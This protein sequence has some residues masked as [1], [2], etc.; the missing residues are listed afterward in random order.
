MSPEGAQHL[1]SVVLSAS[2]EAS[3]AGNPM[4]FHSSERSVRWRL[5]SNCTRCSMADS[6]SELPL[7]FSDQDLASLACFASSCCTTL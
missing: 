7:R 6:V 4:A 5:P 1:S 3:A 2:A